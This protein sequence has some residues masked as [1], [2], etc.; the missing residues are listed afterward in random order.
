MNPMAAEPPEQEMPEAKAA[1]AAVSPPTAEPEAV[2]TPATA[3]EPTTAPA[4]EPTAAP[5]A[6]TTP[7]P[8]PAAARAARLQH[9]MSRAPIGSRER[10]F[11]RRAAERARKRAL[12]E[13]RD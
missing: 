1:H 6:A 10:R 7:T 13:Q 5:D 3:P 11:L 9:E 12:A 4:A 2:S 8:E